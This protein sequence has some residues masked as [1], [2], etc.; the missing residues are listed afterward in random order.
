MNLSQGGATAA[1]RISSGGQGFLERRA[2]LLAVG[3][4]LLAAALRLAVAPIL[5][6]DGDECHTILVSR[7]SFSDLLACEA[8]DIGNPQGFHLLLSAVR[9]VFGENI[10]VYRVVNALIGTAAVAAILML[11]RLLVPRPVIWLGVGLLTALNP[12]QL[13]FSLHLRPWAVQA[14]TLSLA[15]WAALRWRRDRRLWQLVVYVVAMFIAFNTNYSAAFCWAALGLWWLWDSRRSGRRLAWVVGTNLVLLALLVPSGVFLWWQMQHQELSRGGTAWIFHLLGF[16]YFFIYGNSVARPERGRWL[17][18]VTAIPAVVVMAPVLL[19]GLRGVWKTAEP[20][21]LVLTMLILPFLFLAGMCLF[22]PFFFSRYLAFMWPMFAL[23]L[24]L[25]V[26][27]F[28][29][30]LRTV[31]LAALIVMELVGCAGYALRFAQEYPPFLC[32]TLQAHAEKDFGIIFY[33][34]GDRQL[35]VQW[36]GRP[37]ILWIAKTQPEVVVS[38]FPDPPMDY[39]K[40]YPMPREKLSAWLARDLPKEMWL[41]CD[42]RPNT[43]YPDA[44]QTMERVK[45]MLTGPYRLEQTW[46]WPSE[47]QVKYQLLEFRRAQGPASREGA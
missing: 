2:G 38:V 35:I 42:L 19:A 34:S 9:Q 32:R 29:R 18:L 47:K 41:Y 40:L 43:D 25:G 17:M 36:P 16:P 30:R 14:L 10:L 6:L 28:G 11:C 12:M 22:T 5:T 46:S 3:T 44:A 13:T 21:G 31:G 1:V 37:R 33:P 23:T 20:R 8:F 4:V 7:F 45:Q 15:I 26:D 39:V 24:M 27:A